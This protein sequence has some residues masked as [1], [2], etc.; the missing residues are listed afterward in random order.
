MAVKK[1]VVETEEVAVKKTATKKAAEKKTTTK[2]TTAKKTTKKVEKE[3]EV[4]EEVKETKKAPAKKATKKVVAKNTAPVF[5]AVGRRKKSVARIRLMA[6][7]GKVLV[8][9]RELEKYFD[10][11]TLRQVAI[12]PLTLTNTLNK[13]D[14]MVNVTG[15]G[16]TGQANAIRHGI[17]RALVKAEENLKKEIKDAGYLTRD[18]RAK[19]RKKYGLK[20]ARK[21]PQFSKR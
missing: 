21:A 19:E 2:T 6:G 17:A 4:K 13:Y 8:N 14:V 7:T 12:S 15:G 20:K 16:F 3:V 11:E 10:L 1:E 9:K 5:I 18:A